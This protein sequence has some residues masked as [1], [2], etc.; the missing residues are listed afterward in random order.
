MYRIIFSHIGIS[1]K[2]NC[3]AI[4]NFTKINIECLGRS[5]ISLANRVATQRFIRIDISYRVE[6]GNETLTSMSIGVRVRVGGYLCPTSLEFLVPSFDEVWFAGRATSGIEL[7]TSCTVYHII[8]T[9]SYNFFRNKI[10]QQLL[11][12]IQTREEWQK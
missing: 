7:G 1:S 12:N 11:P 9:K 4:T 3:R 8:L 6:E 10:I 5:A 2:K